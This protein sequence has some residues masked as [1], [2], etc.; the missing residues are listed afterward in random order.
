M[1]NLEKKNLIISIPDSR[2]LIVSIIIALPTRFVSLS[3]LSVT[4][5]TTYLFILRYTKQE[6]H[7]FYNRLLTGSSNT[8][9]PNLFMI[10]QEEAT[11]AQN[12][13]A[14]W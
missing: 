7:G 2:L 3:R 11:M 13:M 14:G 1:T 6:I 10:I 8:L 9:L 4:N 5:S 12:T